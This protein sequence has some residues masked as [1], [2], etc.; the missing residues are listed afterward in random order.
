MTVAQTS[1][2]L[3][4]GWVGGMASLAG[5]YGV[6]EYS[7]TSAIGASTSPMVCASASSVVDVFTDTA[8]SAID[9]ERLVYPFK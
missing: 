4:G 6:T 1:L 8:S 3:S 9:W 2:S 5:Q 7:S